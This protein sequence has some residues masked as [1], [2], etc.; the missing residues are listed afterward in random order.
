MEGIKEALYWHTVGIV[1]DLGGGLG[2]AVAI[3]F[4][5]HGILVTANHVVK[6]TDDKD[7][8]FFFRPAGT[9][10][11]DHWWQRSPQTG[12]IEPPWQVRIFDRFRH[13]TD[14]LAVLIVSPTIELEHNVRLHELAEAVALETGS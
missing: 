6:N 2:T 9:L 11:C 13:P 5:G 8:R 7:L 14:D 1:A 10:Q 4:R 3:R 12:K